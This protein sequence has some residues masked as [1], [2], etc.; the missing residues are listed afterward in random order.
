MSE[1]TGPEGHVHRYHAT[2]HWTGDTAMGYENYDRTHTSS[3]PPAWTEL[4]VSA[5]S[6]FLGDPQKLNPEQL[7]VVA[8]SSCQLLSFLAIAARA[9]VQVVEYDDH[10]EA[11]MPEDN[12]PMRLTKLTLRPRIVVGPGVKE[13]RILK[14]T[15]M[16]HTQCYIS[17]SLSTEIVVEPTVEI[18]D[19]ETAD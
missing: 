19:K 18:R 3:A 5:D 4:T 16:A 10:A 6:S 14:L 12:K 13:E 17:N 7:V 1:T 15:E 2:C 9:R 8:V 11:E